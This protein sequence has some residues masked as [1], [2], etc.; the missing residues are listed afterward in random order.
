MPVVSELVGKIRSEGVDQY[1]RDM[2]KAEQ[3]TDKAAKNMA[4]AGK[5]AG[6]LGSSFGDAAK[7]AGTLAVGL[8]AFDAGKAAIGG[9]FSAMESGTKTTGQL[10][11]QLGL[12]KQEAEALGNV[13][14]EVFRNNFAGSLSEASAAAGKVQQI[15]GTMDASAL[16]TATENA[17]RLSDAFGVEVPESLSAVKTIMDNIGLSSEQAFDSEG[18]RPLR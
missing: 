7:Q 17:F 6:G 3:V 16:Q 9:L 14:T 1:A 5:Q 12:T 11:A 18:P 15:L 13:G 2:G 8:G 4:E 10:Q